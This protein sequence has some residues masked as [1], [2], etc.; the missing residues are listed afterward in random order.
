MYGT[1]PWIPKL[2]VS[3][4]GSLFSLFPLCA[5]S[6]NS[7]APQNTELRPRRRR[8]RGGW[9]CH[10]VASSEGIP[11][12]DPLRILIIVR[13]IS[14]DSSYRESANDFTRTYH[15]FFSHMVEPW[16]EQGHTVDVAISTYN[17]ERLDQVKEVYSP[18]FAEVSEKRYEERTKVH[19]VTA[20]LQAAV[21]AG[22]SSRWDFVAITRFDLEMRQPITAFAVD[23]R[24]INFPWRET[25]WR[26]VPWSEMP[27]VGDAMQLF[28]SEFLVPMLAATRQLIR[29]TTAWGSR[30][31]GSYNN[32]HLILMAM[33]KGTVD[34]YKDVN[35]LLRDICASRWNLP[36]SLYREAVGEELA[37][38]Q[39][40]QAPH[41]VVNWAWGRN[42]HR[43]TR[44]AVAHILQMIISIAVF[45]RC[46]C[47]EG[48]VIFSSG[49]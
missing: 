11:Q 1:L 26:D 4:S 15:N 32:C 24:K 43:K 23:F 17:S 3:C 22:G 49:G 19:A 25:N 5:G 46:T 28:P 42:H 41:V 29:N 35:F 13:G 37:R 14:H 27:R 31:H 2:S 8:T 45:R 36:N 18:V 16:R 34:L 47:L 44:P 6:H 30:W 9:S 33:E 38:W 48:R 21:D 40:H 12:P 7:T 20:G 39:K 10:S